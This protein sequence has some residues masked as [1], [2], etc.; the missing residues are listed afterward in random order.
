MDAGED[1]RGREV[2]A[3]LLSLL[4]LGL[5]LAPAAHA[6]APQTGR[7]LVTLAPGRGAPRARVTAAALAATAGARPGRLQRPADPPGHP[8]PARRAPACTPWPCACAPTRAWRASR[9]STAPACAST[10]N[11]PALSTPETAPG[12][13]RARRSSGGRR[14]A[15]SRVAWDVST[16]QGATVAVIDTGAETT[17]S[18]AG[19]PRAAAP[20]AS[21]PTAAPATTDAVGHGTHVAS[22]AC[23]A[24]NNGI[25]LA[26]R[27]PAL[28]DA[29]PQ[30]R[31]QRLERGQGDRLRRRPRR[32]R[33]Q[34]ELRHRPG[35]AA[36]ARP[37]ATPSTTPTQRNVVM[38]AAAADNPIDRA[39]LSGQR[40]AADRHRPRPRRRQGPVGHRG[41][42]RRRARVVRR[43]AAARSRWPP[44]APSTPAR[45]AAGRPGSSAP[46]PAGPTS[47]RPG[48]SR[49]RR[50]RRAAAARPSPATPA[51]PTCRAPR[52][53]RRW[54]RPPARSSATS[55]PTSPSP[56]IVRLIKE[57]ARRPAG[58]WTAE[59]GWGILDAGAALTRAA[60]IDRRAPTS[61]GQAPA[62]AH[63]Q[64]R[65][66]PCAGAAAD[67]APPGVRASGIARFELWRATD[68][69]P[70]K[71]LFTTTRTSRRVT[72]RRG[73]RYASTAS[74]IDHAG[75]R[76]PAPKQADARV[77]R[78]PLGRA[79][80]R[81]R[82][83]RCSRARSSSSA[84]D[85]CD[86]LGDG[87]DVGQRVVVAE[88][89][90]VHARR[91][92]T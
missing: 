88:Q 41:R 68:G 42:R 58:V 80:A 25:G 54:S 5:V 56:T 13:R 53:R 59:L 23:G 67:P 22:L 79:P 34:H 27:R 91:C 38:A 19:R 52:W 17:P 35:P 39:G 89:A 20:R 3:R 65:R 82:P 11:D 77:A 73:G 61:R 55:T 12:P 21:T 90:E 31:L 60:S 92:R 30:V 78:Q 37:S 72:L 6:Q 10:P 15:A 1:E 87:V 57:T 44:T 85:A 63:G 62:G 74:A 86:A 14:A 69:G 2:R 47:S 29:D 16:G 45:R 83:R 49:C 36:H 18:R 70:F 48:R 33:D 51:T 43:A 40:P 76:E 4:A 64:A 81:A 32:R 28:P 8:A 7:L 71:R 84:S 75:N 66:S 24:G 50:A 9:S 46:S 26:G